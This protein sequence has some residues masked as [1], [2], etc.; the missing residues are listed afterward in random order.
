MSNN[1]LHYNKEKVKIYRDGYRSSSNISHFFKS[2]L[3]VIIMGQSPVGS[4]S[5]YRIKKSAR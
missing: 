2:L 4:V 1:S 5:Y 3:S